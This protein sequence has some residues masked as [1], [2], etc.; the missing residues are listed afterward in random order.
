VTSPS[1]LN[2][3]EAF[4]TLEESL[5]S[6]IQDVLTEYPPVDINIFSQVQE[7]LLQIKE[8]F[9]AGN[10]TALDG[11][12]DAIQNLLS[13]VVHSIFTTYGFEAGEDK[14]SHTAPTPQQ[15]LDADNDTINLVVC[16]HFLVAPSPFPPKR[17]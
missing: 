11:W 14:V 9:P 13:S 12:Q 7:A 10:N 15:E 17:H 4:D 8:G 1:A 3:T 16:F 6:T 5:N 2:S